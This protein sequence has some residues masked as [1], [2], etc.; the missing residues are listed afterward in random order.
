MT[1]FFS[2]PLPFQDLPFWEQ[3]S[4]ENLFLPFKKSLE[5]FLKDPSLCPFSLEKDLLLIS[6][7]FLKDPPSSPCDLKKFFETYFTPMASQNN[8][9]GLLTGYYE[10]TLRGSRTSSD[11]YSIPLYKP[12]QDLLFIPDLGCYNPL[13]KAQ[14]WAGRRGHDNQIYPY[15]TRQ[16]IMKGALTEPP[17]LFLEDP[18]S[19]FFLHVQGS[20]KISLE[21]GS[22]IRISY[23]ATNGHPY[24]SLGKT[25]QHKK[26]LEEDPLTKETLETY[27]R[28]LDTKSL[29]KT[30]ALNPSYIFFE[31]LSSLEEGPPGTFKEEVPLTALRSLAVDPLYIPLGLPVWIN[32]FDLKSEISSFFPRLVLAQDTG[33]AIKG[34]K[35]GDLFW[36][37]G[38]AAG[39]KAGLLNNAADMILFWP[40]SPS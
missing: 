35:R 36:G 21:D 10:I 6:K 18:I 33:S 4:F 19:A 39:K 28:T 23:K 29:S 12:P 40:K 24:V 37:T 13:L 8:D 5:S 38:E 27:L 15:F 31:E 34:P 14:R 32:A 7:T 22:V 20:G 1:P 3:E 11:R 17:F 16:D 30:L 9:F 2:K 26:I 25:L